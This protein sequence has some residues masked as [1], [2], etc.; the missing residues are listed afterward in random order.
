MS[1]QEFCKEIK[2]YVES[3][4]GADYKVSIMEVKKLN[5]VTLQSLTVQKSNE[6]MAPNIYLEVLYTKYQDG[7]SIEALLMDIFACYFRV[8]KNFIM[9]LTTL[10]DFNI[11]KNMV[12]L[13]L[14][15]YD[16]NKKLLETIPHQKWHDLA[17]I[18]DVL[19]KQNADEI[20]SFHV[21]NE[22]LEKWG[23]DIGILYEH[24]KI[25]TNRLFGNRVRLMDDIIK[26]III[27]E[28]NIMDGLDISENMIENL[29]PIR[30]KNEVSHDMYVAS[31]S[32]GVYGA[33]WLLYN[34]EI[35]SLS[36]KLDANLYIFPSSIH[37]VIIIPADEKL[38][39]EPLLD[40]VRAVNDTQVPVQDV[41][42]DNVYFFNRGANEIYPLF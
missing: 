2:L 35:R 23:V 4:V 37:E 20:D 9:S 32:S 14:I 26:E 15:N 17:V 22:I 41:L 11:A 28:F 24:A 39:K 5:G 6:N 19:V 16:K 12:F 27:K 38:Q 40:M 33:V 30:N 3:I 10:I 21:N 36:D 7:K 31:N 18:F 42:S 1:Y 29:G 8:P 25:N 34:D 13:K